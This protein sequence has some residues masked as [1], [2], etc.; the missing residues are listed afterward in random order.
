MEAIV[1]GCLELAGSQDFLDLGAFMFIRDYW[2]DG[3]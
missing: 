1:G 2:G 3:G